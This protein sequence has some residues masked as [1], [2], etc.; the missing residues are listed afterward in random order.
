MMSHAQVDGRVVG[1]PV[2]HLASSLVLNEQVVGMY[3][4]FIFL[5]R[6]LAFGHKVSIDVIYSVSSGVDDYDVGV[7]KVERHV[8]DGCIF[9]SQFFADGSLSYEQDEEEY[10]HHN[11]YEDD[12]QCDEDAAVGGVCPVACIGIKPFIVE[13]TD[14]F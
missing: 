5:H 4:G 11:G 8:A 1:H 13:T 10:E 3:H 6:V 9:L 2:V 14:D 7:A 12:K